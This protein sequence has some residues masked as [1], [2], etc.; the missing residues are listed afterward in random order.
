MIRAKI[1]VLSRCV[2]PI[3]LL[4]IVLGGGAGLACCGDAQAEADEAAKRLAL[5]QAEYDK[6]LTAVKAA[7]DKD[8]RLQRLLDLHAEREKLQAVAKLAR[9]KAELE[10]RL[11][12]AIK[13][14]E[15]K[16]QKLEERIPRIDLLA[17]EL[18]K[19]KI[20]TVENGQQVVY[21]NLGSAD[22]VRRGLTFSVFGEAEYKP[23]AE[24][25]AS[26]EVVEIIGEHRC[27]ARVTALKNALR[28][29]LAAGDLLYNPAWT[30]GLRD[31]VAI[32]GVI[33]LNED[34]RDRTAE[35]IKALEKNGAIVDAWIDMKEPAIKG[36]K[37]VSRKTS[38]LI[39]GD[40]PEF[41]ERQ[42]AD[43]PNLEKK[44]A[45]L[46]LVACLRDEAVRLGVCVVPAR[47]YLAL[48]GMTVPKP[49]AEAAPTNKGGT[50][51]K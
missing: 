23:K 18:P 28:R 11:Q 26:I 10:A 5:M 22:F 37:G 13:D 36:G 44:L 4:A 17:L 6:A 21:V 35:F 41:G 15:L 7:L 50:K 32:A 33:D 1:P 38:Y 19:G 9:E 12:E 3:L 47:R 51:D 48:A 2:T 31:H 39:L 42:A 29:P 45:M 24:P 14:L 43:D 25:K 8:A 16:V 34:G 30:P 27:R 20:V 49:A 46:E 40:V